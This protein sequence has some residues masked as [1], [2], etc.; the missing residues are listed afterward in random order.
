RAPDAPRTHRVSVRGL[1]T[2]GDGRVLFVETGDGDLMLPGGGVEDGESEVECLR[3]AR[4]LTPGGRLRSA[5]PFWS[6]TSSPSAPSGRPPDH[7]DLRETRW[8]PK[9]S[10][11]TSTGS[12]TRPSTTREPQR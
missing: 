2:D 12:S 10:S 4:P 11:S 1:V 8:P 7:A 6:R 9:P 3:L 5:V